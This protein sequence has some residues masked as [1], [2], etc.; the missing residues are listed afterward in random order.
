MKKYA[1]LIAG[2][3][4][5][6]ASLVLLYYAWPILTLPEYADIAWMAGSMILLIFIAFFKL[7][8]DI[9]EELL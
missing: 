2:S 9:F 4:S 3:I 7:L 5:G 8:A 6:F 1:K